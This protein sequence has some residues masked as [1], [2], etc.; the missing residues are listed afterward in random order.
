[1][2]RLFKLLLSTATLTGMLALPA[3]HAAES[4]DPVL[5]QRLREAMQNSTSFPNEFAA[6]VWLTDMAIRLGNQVVDPRERIAILR[7]VHQEASR[8]ELPPEIVLAV[9]DIESAFDAYA[10]SDAGAQG[11]MQV[12][13]FWLDEIGRPGDRLIEVGTNLRMGC[14]I[15]KYYFDMENGDWTR[16]LARYNGSLGSRKYPQKVL[17]RL[18]SRWFQQ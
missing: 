15:L 13:P 9:I 5:R 1:M 11:L 8:A 6:Q 16:A 10:V 4:P 7:R 18:R 2:F 3:G 12:M 17:N 14:T